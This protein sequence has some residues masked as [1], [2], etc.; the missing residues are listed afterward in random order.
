MLVK[1]K[2]KESLSNEILIITSPGEG[3]FCKESQKSNLEKGRLGWDFRPYIPAPDM[4]SPISH[5]YE[6]K[7]YVY[8]PN[9]ENSNFGSLKW[10][11]LGKLEANKTLKINY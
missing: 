1:K 3:S 10:V 11:S 4:P 2:K 7:M 9:G 5:I 8:Q 6:D